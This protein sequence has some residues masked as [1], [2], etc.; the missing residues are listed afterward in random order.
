MNPL[1]KSLTN[2]LKVSCSYLL[3][4][5]SIVIAA[6]SLAK[7]IKYLA[8]GDSYTVGESV[9]DSRAWPKQL[10]DYLS[11]KGIK[12]AKPR[13]VAATGW[14]TD[15]LKDTIANLKLNHEY[16]LVSVLVGVNDQY[17]GRSPEEYAVE[18]ESLLLTAIQLAR[19][20][21]GHVFVVSI[22][23]YGYTPYGEF[24]QEKI[25][26]AI[27]QFN[28]INKT[29]ADKY[30]I[31]YFD[32]TDISRQGLMDSSLVAED[33]LHP[34]GLMYHLWVKRI[35]DEGVFQKSKEN[36]AQH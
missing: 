28:A 4:V 25:S 3:W 8:L 23:D 14:R 6:P 12:V 33:G 26:N 15:D 36:L 13:I 10:A 24:D 30:G 9:A 20:G 21:K 5:L 27:D 22:P 1:S 2:T 17:Q 29:L 7:E 32:I 11:Q 34:S 16:D 35:V 19:G 31:A 18:F